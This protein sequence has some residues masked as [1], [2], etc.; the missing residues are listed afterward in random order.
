MS[1]IS[2]LSGKGASIIHRVSHL[3]GDRMPYRKEG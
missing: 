3:S 2:R 1:S